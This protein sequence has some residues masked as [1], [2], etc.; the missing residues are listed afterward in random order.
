LVGLRAPR[1]KRLFIVIVILGASA[2][3]V[4]AQSSSLSGTLAEGWTALGTGDVAKAGKAADRALAD[5]PRSAAAVALA[6]EVDIAKGGPVAGLDVYERWL[7]NRRVDDAYVLRRIA[8]AHLRSVVSARKQPA[9][10]EARKALAADGDQAAAAE[11]SKAASTGSSLEAA[12]AA[13]IGDRAAIDAMIARLQDP[14]PGKVTV[15]EALGNAGS[16]RAIAPL[17]KLLSDPRQ[18]NRAAAAEALGKLGA[19]DAIPQLRALLNDPVQPVQ[20]AA[21][22]ALYRLQDMSGANVLDGLLTSEYP[23]VRLSAAEMMSGTPTPTWQ[24]IVKSLL[25]E[26]DELVQLRAARLIAPYDMQAAAATLE[27]LGQSQNMAIR[28]EAAKAYVN[29]LAADFASLRRYLRNADPVTSVA[30]AS[31]IL[32]LTRK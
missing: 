28:E 4:F 21:A 22:G 15:I 1:V 31:R 16:S 23:T 19:A 13:S 9:L 8:E 7:G 18:E 17:M 11:L 32:E 12:A 25:D 2:A 3:P 30:A 6:V 29:H 10:T 20:F 5:A 27:R 26:S 24:S 14:M